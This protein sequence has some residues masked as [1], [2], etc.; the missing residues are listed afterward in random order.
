MW[1]PSS[2]TRDWTPVPD[3][4]LQL[5]VLKT[6]LPGKSFLYHTPW[7]NSSFRSGLRC[8]MLE[9]LH[10][11]KT[12]HFGYPHLCCC[13]TCGILIPKDFPQKFEAIFPVFPRIQCY[14]CSYIVAPFSTLLLLLPEAFRVFSLCLSSEI[15]LKALIRVFPSVWPW[16]CSAVSRTHTCPQSGICLPF[17]PEWP[18]P[19]V[20]SVLIS[21]RSVKWMLATVGLV[22]PFS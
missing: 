15:S 4:H 10:V 16:F 13:Y 8:Q 19:T 2:P 20:F 11:W 21:W 18:L 3:P 9:S 6:G 7:A 12:S 22:L 14:F 5:G 1:D 17:L